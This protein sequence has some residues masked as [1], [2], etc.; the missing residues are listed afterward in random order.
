MICT[1]CTLS[2]RC[3]ASGYDAI[4]TRH[5]DKMQKL[6]QQIWH[7][8][9]QNRCIDMSVTFWGVA[10]NRIVY[11]V[12]TICN[13][14]GVATCYKKDV[15]KNC[16]WCDVT[17]CLKLTVSD[18]LQLKLLHLEILNTR[19]LA[20]VRQTFTIKRNE[21]E[22]IRVYQASTQHRSQWFGIIS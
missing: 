20:S 18:C 13:E 17:I 19:L 5:G 16:V 7:C 10:Q 22:S 21:D 9:P 3:K 12:W 8:A 6:Q 11:A 15:V 14:N 4:T 2:R 1:G